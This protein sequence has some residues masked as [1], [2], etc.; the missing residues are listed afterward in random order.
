MKG[1]KIFGIFLGLALS[2]CQCA[3]AQAASLISAN[4]APNQQIAEAS[5]PTQGS[6][7]QPAS[8]V[9]E[10]KGTLPCV[11]R[12]LQIN[13]PI[14][15]VWQ[16][17]QDRR[18]SDPQHRQ[19]LSYD[20]NVAVVKEVFPSMPI[21]GTSIATY[22]ER[23]VRPLRQIAYKLVA[24]PKFRTFEG[25]WT[26]TP[27]SAP[28]TTLVNLTLTF[29]PGIRFPLWERVARGNMNKNVRDTIQEVNRLAT[30]KP[31]H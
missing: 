30:E 11:S 12:Q 3:G 23:E 17:I 24:S 27:G 6:P 18:K 22:S 9:H 20:G 15:R 29:D 13:A 25:C 31:A 5:Q 4:P 7:S 28:N 19:L 14:E 8:E 26:L 10:S 21:L 16:A 1:R 2:A